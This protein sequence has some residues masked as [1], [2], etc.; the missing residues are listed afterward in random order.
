MKVFSVNHG[1]NKI[2]SRLVLD[3]FPDYLYLRIVTLQCVIGRIF[4]CTWCRLQIS[5]VCVRLRT[6]TFV[7]ANRPVACFPALER[8]KFSNSWNNF[9]LIRF[10]RLQIL[11]VFLRLRQDTRFLAFLTDNM[12]SAF[13]QVARFPRAYKGFIFVNLAFK[14]A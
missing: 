10:P 4:F 13:F 14:N 6:Y 3:T 5:R 8:K 7:L 11:Q 12:F 1:L 2:K 9:Q